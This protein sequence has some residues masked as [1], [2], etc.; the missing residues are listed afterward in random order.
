MTEILDKKVPKWKQNIVVVGEKKF[1]KFTLSILELLS[2]YEQ[3]F[4]FV[5]EHIN[6]YMESVITGTQVKCS[7]FQYNLDYINND[8]TSK[9]SQEWMMSV[10]LH[11]ATHVQLY[12]QNKIYSGPKSELV[13]NRNQLKFMEKI[14]KNSF[15]IDYLKEQIKLNLTGKSHADGGYFNRKY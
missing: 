4:N 5:K 14:N 12:R 3:E 9:N 2:K 13:C 11:E 8:L 10:F 6:V 7:A 1:Q 15:Y